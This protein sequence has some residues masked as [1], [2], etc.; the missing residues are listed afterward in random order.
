[1]KNK[2]SKLECYI[3]NTVFVFLTVLLVIELF[4]SLDWRMVGDTA[5]GSYMGFLM[6]KF[7]FIPYKDIFSADA[8]GAY[9][10][11]LF[12]SK[13]FGYGDRAFR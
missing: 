7:N 9:F 3:F 8:P 2:D 1:M 6:D 4:F 12:I 5:L 10:F 11:H 13:M